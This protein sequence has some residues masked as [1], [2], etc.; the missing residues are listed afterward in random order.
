[1]KYL[2]T[3]HDNVRRTCVC[4]GDR[5]YPPHIYV[6]VGDDGITRVVCTVC[7]RIHEQ[8]GPSD[9][10]PVRA[11]VFAMVNEERAA[12]DKVWRDA[13]NPTMNAQY[14]YAAPH[15]LVLE[16][17]VAKLRKIW[18]GSKDEGSLQDRFIKTAACAVRAVEE[19]KHTRG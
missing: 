14:R 19:I 4:T 9:T 1:M 15:I 12:Q 10:P 11:R 8:S 5:N 2:I 16:E 3:V 17:C 7:Q 6:V 18:Y 13:D